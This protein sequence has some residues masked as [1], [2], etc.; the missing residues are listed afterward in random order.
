MK[1]KQTRSY[2]SIVRQKQ[3]EE[4]KNR[5]ADA[6]EALIKTQGYENTTIGA[7]AKDAGVAT[8]TVYA[9]FN[10]KQGIL[11]HL[12]R[13]SMKNVEKM[14]TDFR[15]LVQAGDL[16]KLAQQVAAATVKHGHEQISTL[17]SL[18]GFEILY[19]ELHNLMSEASEAR[20]K[21]VENG[22]TQGLNIRGINL[23]PQKKKTLVDIMWAFTD[24][25]LYYTL[26]IEA[27]WSQSSYERLFQKILEVLF[28][29]IAPEALDMV[30]E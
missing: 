26:V 11:M 13:R 29:E 16:S 24:N 8:Q 10:S 4:T 12:L 25:H 28:R 17:N 18:G 19:P 9:V 2:N 21:S 3:A 5:I 7:I 6:A 1:N 14:D 27:G 15:H 30:D 20:R 22:I 23:T